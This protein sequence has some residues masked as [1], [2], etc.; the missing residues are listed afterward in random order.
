MKFLFAITF[1]TTASLMNAT[2]VLASEPVYSLDLLQSHPYRFLPAY[3]HAS[4]NPGS[5]KYFVPGYGY[6]IPGFGWNGSVVGAD[7]YYEFGIQL[8][9]HDDDS[10]YKFW[11]NSYGNPWYRPGGP[12]TTARWPQW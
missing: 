1:V 4:Q 2:G 6:R 3:G 9:N 11:S 7:R 5:P 8:P 12:N 10:K